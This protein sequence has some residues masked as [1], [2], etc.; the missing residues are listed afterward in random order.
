[1][2]INYGFGLFLHLDFKVERELVCM[3]SRH[4]MDTE[5][6]WSQK[7]GLDLTG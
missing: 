5:L 2:N 6:T 7:I 1:M 4:S 3:R